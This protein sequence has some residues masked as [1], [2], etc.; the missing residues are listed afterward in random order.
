MRSRDLNR[1][2]LFVCLAT[3]MLAGCGG[4]QPPIAASGTIPQAPASTGYKALYSFGKGSDGRKPK[5]ALIDV[6]GTF[7]GT[8][9]GGGVYSDGT[10]FSMS[11]TGTEKVLYSFQGGSDGANPSA[12]LLAVKGV[13]YGTTEH[14]GGVDGPGTVFK[15]STSGIEKVL[16]SFGHFPDGSHPLSSLIDVKGT[17]YGTTYQG[18]DDSSCYSCGTVYSISTSGKEKVLHNFE[19]YAD[20]IAPFANLI[21]VKGTLY[22]TTQAGIGQTG[23]NLGFGTVFRISTTGTENVLYSFPG[24]YAN[25]SYPAA[26]LININGTLYGTTGYGGAYAN[27]YGHYGTAFSITTSGSLTTL[28]SFGS[29]TDR[30]PPSC[31]TA[32]RE[33]HPLRND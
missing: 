10:V 17:L 2:V 5:A 15:I 25:G 33:R 21:D 14:D 23:S 26:G 18:G 16:H 9:Y 32:Q 13:L 8:T 6:N 11:T 31:T 3:V 22:G 4:S 24:Y 20:G 12:S 19:A 7:Y 1:F 28:H 30:R 27:G 29:G